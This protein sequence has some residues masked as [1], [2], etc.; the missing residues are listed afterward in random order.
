MTLKPS[1][2]LRE[3]PWTR[4]RC[5]SP[6][7]TR[8]LSPLASR[9]RSGCAALTVMKGYLDDA[10]A[11]AGAITSDGWLR[12]GDIGVMDERGYLRIT[13]RLK[14][15]YIC[16]GFNCYPAEIEQ[17]LLGHPQIDDVAVLGVPDERLGEVGHA[18]VVTSAEPCADEIIEW[19]RNHM[20]NFKAPRKVSICR[21][22]CP[23]TP[24]ARCRNFYCRRECRD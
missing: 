17:I 12:T 1:P 2:P 5:K 9:E 11:T 24:P 18:F 16:G 8:C 4:S 13:D 7:P 15:M 10:E 23:G 6:V 19:A 21:C 3:G 14:D 22:T 20:A